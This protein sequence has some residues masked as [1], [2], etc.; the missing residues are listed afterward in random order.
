M[1]PSGE[2]S[3]ER[4]PSNVPGSE[5]RGKAS[6]PVGSLAEYQMFTPSFRRGGPQSWEEWQTSTVYST[7]PKK[8]KAHSEKVVK[9]PEETL[10]QVIEDAVAKALQGFAAPTAPG[11]SL[12]DI[13]CEK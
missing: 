7:S 8:Q 3:G 6:E 4:P 11:G 13:C 12:E 2:G 9:I 5:A 10:L 1:S